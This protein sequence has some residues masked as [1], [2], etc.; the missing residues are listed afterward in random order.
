MKFDTEQIK[1][2][3]LKAVFISH[4]HD[5]HCSFESLNLLNRETPIYIYCIFDE[6]ISLI[7]ELGFKNVYLLQIDETVVVGSFAVTPRLALDADVDC[8]LQIKAEDLNVLNVVDAWIDPAALEKLSVEKWD[9]VLWPFQTMLEMN[10]LSPLSA[11]PAS[12]ELPPEWIEQIKILNP[13]FLVPSSCQFRFEEWSWYNKAFFPISYKQFAK[14]INS[15]LPQSQVV[16]INPGVSVELT[17]QALNTVLPLAWITP[18]GGQDVDY[19]Y[20]PQVKAPPV[21][22]IAKQLGV[23]TPEQIARVDK[24]CRSEI[25]EK[26]KSMSTVENKIWKLILYNQNGKSQEFCYKINNGELNLI[27][28]VQKPDWLTEIPAVKLYGALEAGESLT[29]L[30]LRIHTELKEV[31]ILEDPLLQCLYHGKTGAYQKAQLKNIYQL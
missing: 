16:R 26:F 14:E 2:L 9:M 4:Y 11:E 23:L 29:S 22:E 15:A 27:T 30:Y 17:S 7:R 10:V 25:I 1:S 31:D 18:V 24:Y 13:R 19:E 20:D 28:S 5:D 21:S 6:V 8:V 3:Q 12:T